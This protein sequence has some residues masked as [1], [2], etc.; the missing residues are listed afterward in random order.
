MGHGIE[1]HQRRRRQV[2]NHGADK[3]RSQTKN[4]FTNTTIASATLGVCG[5]GRR[6]IWR[7]CERNRD[8]RPT[9]A[10]VSN[11]IINNNNT[12]D[13]NN[14]NN[15]NN[16]TRV[17]FFYI[18]GEKMKGRT[19]GENRGRRAVYVTTTRPDGYYNGISP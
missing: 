8:R 5:N 3:R 11:T 18:R 17:C 2:D 6:N 1:K 16:T 10:H 12:D 19:D 7:P 13:N 14:N 4:I 9:R 15:N